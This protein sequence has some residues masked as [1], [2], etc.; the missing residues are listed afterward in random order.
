MV[1]KATKSRKKVVRRKRSWH[2][3]S[4]KR[5]KGEALL[6]LGHKI[7]IFLI[8]F[9]TFSGLFWNKLKSADA[10][11]FK[12]VEANQIHEKLESEVQETRQ[13]LAFLG[14]A[15]QF[16]NFEHDISN[17]KDRLY[18]INDRLRQN[19]TDKERKV[20]MDEKRELENDIEKLQTEQLKLK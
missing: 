8:A 10:R 19:I 2:S 16:N 4:L 13:D 15:F 7:L 11:Y 1:K 14:K 17:K 18:K 20:L 3:L 5:A 6:T 9:F 12:T